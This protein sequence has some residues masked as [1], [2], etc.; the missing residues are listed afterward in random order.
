MDQLQ[1]YLPYILNGAGGAILAPIIAGLLGGKGLGTIGN[2]I[3]GIVGGIGVGAGAQAAGFGNLLGG[4]TNATMGYVQDLLE[5]GIGG[6]ILGAI[7]GF[8]KGKQA[9]S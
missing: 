4:D 8:V 5:G 1:Q 6:G 9:A 3:A 2:I 7:L